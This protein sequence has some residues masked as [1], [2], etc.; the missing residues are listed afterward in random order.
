MLRF[1]AN[2]FGQSL[3]A[4]LHPNLPNL[5]ADRY[6]VIYLPFYTKEKLKLYLGTSIQNRSFLGV[7]SRQTKITKILYNKMSFL[8]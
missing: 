3:Q 1:L 5:L 8:I 4:A 7:T 2:Y 6:S